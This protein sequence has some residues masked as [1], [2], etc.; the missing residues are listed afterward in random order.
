MLGTWDLVTLTILPA[1]AGSAGV[2]LLVGRIA[3]TGTSRDRPQAPPDPFPSPPLRAATGLTA[4]ISLAFAIAVL[5][6]AVGEQRSVILG[7]R[8]EGAVGSWPDWWT[9]G[10]TAVASF[11]Q[12]HDARQWL[13]AVSAALIAT[14][15]L[16]LWLWRFSRYLSALFMVVASAA[17]VTRVLWGS[18][19]LTESWSP[20]EWIKRMSGMGLSMGLSL[21]TSLGLS[22]GLSMGL[23]MG[24][25]WWLF[26]RRSVQS[27]AEGTGSLVGGAGIAGALAVILAT[28][29]SLSYGTTAGA[30]ACAIAGS[31]LGAW[32]DG[33]QCCS[34][35]MAGP[36]CVLGGTLLVLGVFY[37]DVHWQAA[38]GIIVG[39]ALLALWPESNRPLFAVGRVLASLIPAIGGAAWAIWEFV[40]ATAAASENPYDIYR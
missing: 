30:L 25:L 23:G 11:I 9:A 13:P 10:R 1:L 40:Q 2:W 39:T 38:A 36:L 20:G 17:V 32:F 35:G 34:A 14:T 18:I 21:G 27:D 3:E 6:H 4:A 37:A 12:P 26:A 29:G 19:Y 33:R 8:G 22:L 15:A 24:S 31:W 28:S 5:V 7:L 16:A